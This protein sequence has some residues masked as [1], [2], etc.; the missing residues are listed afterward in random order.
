M[1]RISLRIIAID[2]A[3]HFVVLGVLAVAGLV[4]VPATVVTLYGISVLGGAG[5]GVRDPHPS[6]ADRG[7]VASGVSRYAAA[8]DKTAS[9]LAELSALGVRRISVGGALA[10]SAWGGFIRMAKEIAGDR[11]EG[12]KLLVFKPGDRI[13]HAF[14]LAV[15]CY[16]KG[17]PDD[18]P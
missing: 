4:G 3:I 7:D 8:L 10:R 14:R 9:F 5:R 11:F 15:A 17:D 2:R 16:P 13:T 12:G 18:R 1:K 6:G